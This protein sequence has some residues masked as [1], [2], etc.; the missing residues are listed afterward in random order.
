MTHEPISAERAQADGNGG[1][2]HVVTGAAPAGFPVWESRLP[3]YFG[4][5]SRPVLRKLRHE[6]LSHGTDWVQD[7]EKRVCLSLAAVEKLRGVLMPSQN[8]KTPGG[9]A[10]D[11]GGPSENAENAEKLAALSTPLPVVTLEVARTRVVNPRLILCRHLDSPA[12]L[13]RVQVRD[14]TRYFTHLPNGQ[15]ATVEARQVQGD[16]YEVVGPPPR[17]PA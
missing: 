13:V 3:E 7:A 6:H 8:E 5:V 10:S 15:P 12:E 2:N 11:A 14:N 17:R 1:A 4:A 16:L 9:P